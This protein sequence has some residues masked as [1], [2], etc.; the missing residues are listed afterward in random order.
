MPR[1]RPPQDASSPSGSSLR[2]LRQVT[3]TFAPARSSMAHALARSRHSWRNQT[4]SPPPITWRNDI[5]GTAA[6]FYSA[7][8][9]MQRTKLAAVVPTDLGW[10]DIGSWSSVWDVLVRDASGNA[11]DGPVV[12]LD[13]R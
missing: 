9:V 3:A 6:I 8:A 10:S 7:Y 12:M 1:L 4:P 2:I 13:S 5:C 11:T